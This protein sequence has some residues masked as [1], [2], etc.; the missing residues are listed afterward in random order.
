M[1]SCITWCAIWW[2]PSLLSERELCKPT[3][4]FVFSNRATVP[5]RAQLL[6]Q[7]ACAWS[8][9]STRSLRT[10]TRIDRIFTRRLRLA[11]ENCE[12]FG[13]S[14]LSLLVASQRRTCHSQDCVS[15]RREECPT[16][17]CAGILNSNLSLQ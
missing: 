5:P 3:T 9:S 6:P 17:F 10:F 13:R 8:L 7:A 1:V 16:H 14:L 4:L 2:A 11:V 15:D 12:S